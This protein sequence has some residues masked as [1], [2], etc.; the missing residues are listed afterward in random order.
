MQACSTLGV[1]GDFSPREGFA[2]PEKCVRAPGGKKW[3]TF[4]QT[5][6]DSTGGR[7]GARD[8]DPLM[9]FLIALHNIVLLLCK[10]DLCNL[11]IR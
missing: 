5:I 2:S 10:T 3:G 8:A 7:C 9:W 1:Q 6:A 4:S 11:T